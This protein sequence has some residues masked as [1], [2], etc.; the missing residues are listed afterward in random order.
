MNLFC[1]ILIETD[2]LEKHTTRPP[3]ARMHFHRY[4]PFIPIRKSLGIDGSSTSVILV[5]LT[6]FEH[7][8]SILSFK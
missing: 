1:V 4:R 8:S 6:I 2:A 5:T 7:L 3:P